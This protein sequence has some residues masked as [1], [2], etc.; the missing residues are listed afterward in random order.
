MNIDKQVKIMELQIHSTNAD[1][2]LM[3]KMAYLDRFFKPDT[4]FSQEAID[5]VIA[6]ISKSMVGKGKK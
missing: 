1:F 4:D 3:E 2:T 6:N 5:I